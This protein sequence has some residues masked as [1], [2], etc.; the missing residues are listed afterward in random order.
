MKSP[1]TIALLLFSILL[2]SCATTVEKSRFSGDHGTAKIRGMWAVCYMTSLK[3]QPQVHPS[4]HIAI[5]DCMIDKSR[6][7]Y[8]DSD[9]EDIGQE[10]LTDYF[11][12]LFEECREEQGVVIPIKPAEASI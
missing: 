5:C 9:Y 10:K 1:K 6:E 12:G 11:R 8:K 2:T 3:N 4:F 7:K